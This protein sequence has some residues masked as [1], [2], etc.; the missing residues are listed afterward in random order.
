MVSGAI[1]NELEKLYY[2]RRIHVVIGIV[3]VFA[4]LMMVINYVDKNE[5]IEDWKTPIES[6]V[7]EINRYLDTQLDKK[8]KEYKDMVNQ[9][10]KLEYH[11]TH[12]INP[13]VDG[14]VG[15]A[16]S[17]VT[18]MFIKIILPI[19]IVIITADILSGEASN[20]TLKSLLV[21]PMGRKRLLFSKWIAATLISIGV[22]LL[23][24]FLTYLT[25][26]P[27][28]GL[29]NWNDLVVVGQEDF[30]G[31]QVWKYMIQGLLLNTLMI[32]TLTSVFLLVSVLFQSIAIS[33][34]LSICI[35]VFG[36]ILASLQNKIDQLKYFF[37]LNLDL[38]AHLT[39]QFDLQNTSL[40][41]SS[42]VM[43]VTLIVALGLSF[44]IFTKKDLLV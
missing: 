20:G 32:V 4:V 5:K 14:A 27:F 24:D 6:Q 43:L 37:M 30:S 15:A 33:I 12:N 39:G 26:I 10:E 41:I 25:A 34:S 28:S 11:L 23:S 35:V 36:G 13:E 17:G 8:S 2:K 1:K 31:I 22:M 44:S 42:V 3:L 29:G 21:S 9:R 16:I 40:T 18:G 7:T 19:L 38:G